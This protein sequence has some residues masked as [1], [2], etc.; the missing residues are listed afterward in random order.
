[1]TCCYA[2]QDKVWAV[3]PD[4]NKWEVYVV[5]DDNAANH[6][7]S[8]GDCCP[9]IPVIMEAVQRHDMPAAARAFEKAGGMSAC[10]CLA[11]SAT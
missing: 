3:D 1:M 7:G 11:S 9:E 4:G 2:V 5:L 6:H 8:K 10:S